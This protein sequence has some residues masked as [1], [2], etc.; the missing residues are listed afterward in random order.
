MKRLAYLL[1]L[2]VFMGINRFSS[3]IS[4]NENKAKYSTA[5]YK[6]YKKEKAFGDSSILEIRHVIRPK[7]LHE[8]A[9]GL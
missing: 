2:V 1:L 9:S 5:R 7:A 8:M 3:N 4:S 6:V